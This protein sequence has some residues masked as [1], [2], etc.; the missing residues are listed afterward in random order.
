M[1]EII[2]DNL[3]TITCNRTVIIC[4]VLLIISKLFNNNVTYKYYK[5]SI[6][7]SIAVKCAISNIFLLSNDR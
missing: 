4:A 3:T 2:Q 1:V 7:D 6:I 5:L